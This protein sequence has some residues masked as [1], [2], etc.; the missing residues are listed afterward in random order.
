MS[1]YYIE[2][3]PFLNKLSKI[4]IFFILNFVSN[5][6]KR[7]QARYVPEVI[8]FLLSNALIYCTTLKDSRFVHT[9]KDI[10]EILN[11]IEDLNLK[12]S[13]S[14][15]KKFNWDWFVKLYENQAKYNKHSFQFQVLR[16]YYIYS[17]PKL[18][19]QFI[20]NYGVNYID[21]LRS[22]IVIYSLFEK[23]NW[24]F[25]AN[26]LDTL[27]R[28]QEEKTPLNLKD[29]LNLSLSLLSTDLFS[30]RNSLKEKMKYDENMFL[31]FS[32]PHLIKPI[33]KID[34]YLC[35]P[36]TNVLLNQFT[37]GLYYLLEL[38]Q[39]QGELG[40]EYGKAF[41]KYIGLIFNKLSTERFNVISEF[42]YFRKGVEI[43]SPDW[44][45]V[46]DD[47]VTMIECKTKRKIISEKKFIEDLSDSYIQFAI[48]TLCKLYQK[49]NDYINDKF[50]CIT[51]DRNKSIIPIVLFLEDDLYIDIDNKISKPLKNLLKSKGL[52][53]NIVDIYPPKFYN[54]SNFEYEVFLMFKYGF[55]NY[56]RMKSNNQITHDEDAGYSYNKI[57]SVEFN[58]LFINPFI[59]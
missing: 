2:L 10:I 7:E 35:C 40:E 50:E 37:G 30:L 38:N 41:E 31:Q 48:T 29:S 55:K 56:F 59:V 54:T 9:E 53:D 36:N 18:A 3:K 51:Y 24:I 27:F 14:I 21:F 13:D 43:R 45:I 58:D 1:G 6:I 26:E 47:S 28:K 15:F 17:S 12:I 5:E 52:D 39:L 20:N 22:S 46:E 34:N 25:S 19:E 8:N 23:K 32:Y 33:F 42:K 44:I 4:N 16:Y 11:K 49:V 57:F